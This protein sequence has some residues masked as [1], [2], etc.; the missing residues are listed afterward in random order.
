MSIDENA[1]LMWLTMTEVTK[2]DI[3]DP[4][5]PYREEMNGHDYD[6]RMQ[7]L[8]VEL[9]KM[10]RCVIDTGQRRSARSSGRTLRPVLA[11]PRCKWCVHRG[12]VR[13]TSWL[14][15]TR[16]SLTTNRL[17]RLLLNSAGC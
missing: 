3:L 10:L 1:R 9:V 8:Q 11:S 13:P 2:D 14:A 16:V 12:F 7:A 15:I 4:G 5:Y 17:C 6:R